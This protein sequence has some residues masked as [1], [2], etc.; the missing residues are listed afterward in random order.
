MGFYPGG[1]GC[2]LRRNRVDM[3]ITAELI[4]DAAAADDPSAFNAVRSRQTT[5]YV[6]WA[7]E[8]CDIPQCTPTLGSVARS[9]Q[10]VQAQC[11]AGNPHYP[12]V[13][14]PDLTPILTELVSQ[15]GWSAG[16]SV[17]TC[18]LSLCPF[19]PSALDRSL[20]PHV[21]ACATRDTR[22]MRALH[23]CRAGPLLLTY[24]AL[25]CTARAR[26]P[27]SSP[28]L[29]EAMSMVNAVSVPPPR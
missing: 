5:A 4:A 20:R 13:Y 27:C 7:L 12:L 15:S 6:N 2:S 29:L 17:S 1:Y 16:N 21:A 9:N 19:F 14:T 25:G 18:I 28:P 23:V 24:P 3:V 8:P 26:S 10:P 22:F 11:T